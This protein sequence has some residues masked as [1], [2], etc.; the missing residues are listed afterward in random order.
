M[1]VW[2]HSIPL[3]FM[4]F[5][6][7]VFVSF[8][9]YFYGFYGFFCGLSLILWTCI[10]TSM[11]TCI[12]YTRKCFVYSK[13]INCCWSWPLLVGHTIFSKPC[14]AHLENTMF[15]YLMCHF[16]VRLLF[17]HLVRGNKSQV[18]FLVV[19]VL[20]PQLLCLVLIKWM[21]THEPLVFDTH[22]KSSIELSNGSN[23]G[24]CC[25]TRIICG[26]IERWEF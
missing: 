26:Y 25:T 23:I 8:M 24:V 14:C 6:Y 9:W 7:G 1:D 5:S 15:E 20:K 21:H 19:V 16:M 13:H 17:Q 12:N 10:G 2:I 22:I 4:W 3:V 11:E 18:S